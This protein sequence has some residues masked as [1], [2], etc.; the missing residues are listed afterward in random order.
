VELRLLGPTELRLDGRPIEL[1]PRKQRAVLAML[2]LEAGRTISADRLVEGLWGD[3]PPSSAAKMVQLYVSRL[4][5]LFDGNG[6]RIVTQGRG[7][8]LDMADGDVDAVR[9]ERLLAERRPREAL[10][11]WH[12]DALADLADEPFA[13]EEIRR[14]GELRLRASETAIDADLEAGRHGDVIGELE[15]L[16]AEQPLR[17]H[18]RAQHMLALYRAGRQSDALEA[19]RGARAAL[20]DEVGVEPGAEL[21]DLQESILAH[22]PAL[23]IGRASCRERV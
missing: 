5:R 14:L 13:A 22:D 15:R 10:A 2:G 11:L 8:E 23:E 17:E 4:R 19:Y 9:F 21:R 16:I 18:L 3:E 6:V 1:G 20:V 12:G 7:Y